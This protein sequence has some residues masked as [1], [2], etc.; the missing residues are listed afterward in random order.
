M[1]SYLELTGR[2]INFKDAVLGL[3]EEFAS[4]FGA[5]L[6]PCDPKMLFLEGGL[7]DNQRMADAGSV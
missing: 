6:K 3:A 2:N 4:V 1:T 5:E 7:D